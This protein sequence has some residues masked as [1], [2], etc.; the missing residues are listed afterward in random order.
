MLIELNA[1]S[2]GFFAVTLLVIAI[3]I[4][5]SIKVMSQYDD[6]PTTKESAGPPPSRIISSRSNKVPP[7]IVAGKEVKTTVMEFVKFAGD[8][9]VGQRE[10]IRKNLQAARENKQVV[11]ILCDESFNAQKEDHSQALLVL[12]LLGE[13]KSSFAT[14]CLNRFMNLPFPKTGTNVDGEIIE[15]TALATLQAKAIDG[16]AYLNTVESN[17]L[18][19][20]AVKNHPSIIVRAEA[21]DAYLWNHR[22]KLK[23]ARKM[24]SQYV[25]K[26]E[27]IY[28]DRVRRESGET[29][30]T[31]N[32]KLTAFLKAHPEAVAPK[33]ETEKEP[34]KNKDEKPTR[35]AKP[36]KF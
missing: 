16:L 18:V 1:R 15:Q 28:L 35:I 6:K 12:S 3:G 5:A 13:M 33:P 30:E 7:L 32:R 11:K 21:I 17:K 8:T 29:A 24:L 23:E 20:D 22:D 25:R 34:Y 2:I 27:E 31:F 9:G 19:L 26:G 14:E 4:I 10:E 36:P